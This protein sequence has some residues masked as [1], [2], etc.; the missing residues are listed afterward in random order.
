MPANTAVESRLRREAPK[1]L[2]DPIAS[3]AAVSDPESLLAER[4]EG[5]I[6]GE[7][8]ARASHREKG[9]ERIGGGG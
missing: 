1:R 7:H 9:S 8:G 4:V 5:L 6:S 3:Y 2:E